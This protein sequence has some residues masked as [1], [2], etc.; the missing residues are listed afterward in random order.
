MKIASTQARSEYS[1]GHEPGLHCD[2]MK[3][4]IRGEVNNMRND[5]LPMMPNGPTWWVL[6]AKRDFLSVLLALQYR[7]V[8]VSQRQPLDEISDICSTVRRIFPV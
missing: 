5:N 6:E 3:D 2:Y 8:L 4:V 1:I 7:H